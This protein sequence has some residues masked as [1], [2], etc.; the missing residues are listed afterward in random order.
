M[1]KNS[2]TPESSIQKKGYQPKPLTNGHRP[3]VQGGHQ[4]EKG[5]SP[6]PPPPRK[7]SGGKN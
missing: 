2:N 1:K 7:G 3:S 4:P 5:G 6:P